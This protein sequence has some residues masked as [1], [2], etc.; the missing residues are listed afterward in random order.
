MNKDR[1]IATA[2]VGEEVFDK[3][4]ELETFIAFAAHDLRSPI[5]QM[6]A[7][8]DLIADDFVDMG[9]GKLQLLEHLSEV[10]ASSYQVLTD[11]L[12]YAET[13]QQEMPAERFCLRDLC[14]TQAHILDTTNRL[15]LA[16]QDVELLADKVSLGIVLRNLIDNAL[17]YAAKKDVHIE[18][19][20]FADA[21]NAL[22][23]EVSDDGEGFEDPSA[24]FEWKA[25][26]KRTGGFGLQGLK[27]LIEGRGGAIMAVPP[28]SGQGAHFRIYFPG[29]MTA[30]HSSYAKTQGRLCA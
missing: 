9:D 21:P 7:L 2:A 16:V 1:Q 28:V 23:L 20:V 24:V 4:K 26:A 6:Q 14:Q 10:A 30:A 17:R 5:G 22:R 15:T 12:D 27:R 8:V 19:A 3:V 11:V 18:I 29:R 13:G 25:K